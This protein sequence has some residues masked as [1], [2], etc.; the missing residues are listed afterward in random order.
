VIWMSS[1]DDISLNRKF[2]LRTEI[3]SEPSLPIC[4]EKL[5]INEYDLIITSQYIINQFK[6]L[7]IFRKAMVM[8]LAEFGCGEPK[9]SWVNK[10]IFRANQFPYKRVIAIGGGTTIDI[11]KLCIFGDGRNVKELFTDKLLLT[12]KRELIAIPTTCG[13]GSEV[14]SVSV[15]EFD[16]LNSKLGL[17]I[18]LLFPDKAILVGEL[19]RP[20]PYKI[21]AITSIDALAHAVESL[22]SPKANLY[23]DM[24]AKTAI[25]GIIE[26]LAEIRTKHC[27]PNDMQ[28]S[29]VCAN[30]AGIAFSNAGCATMHALSFPLSANYNLSHGEAVYAVFGCV[31][32]Y[33]RL[34]GVKLDKLEKVLSIAFDD[35]HDPILNLLNLLKDIYD[36]PDL[37][38]LGVTYRECEKMATSVYENQQRLLVNSPIT[39][40]PDNLADIYK[41]CL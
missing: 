15:V 37:K 26:N 19:L 40:N 27:L 1:L 4:F 32:E 17:Q 36:C 25:E 16:D 8:N 34:L 30:M 35:K 41:N 22:L 21:F 23:T 10:I 7:G 39:L 5:D 6:E 18:D 20:L 38:T 12:K 28:K 11:A 31:L 33:Y 13:T 29:L 24:Y 14:T 9:E 3:Y 2:R